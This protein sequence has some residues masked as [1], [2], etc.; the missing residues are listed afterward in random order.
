MALQGVDVDLGVLFE[1]DAEEVGV[2]SDFGAVVE[3]VTPV[4]G[5]QGG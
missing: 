5:L 3:V 1:V 2:E 4:A